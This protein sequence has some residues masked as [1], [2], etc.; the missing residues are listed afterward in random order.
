[1]MMRIAIARKKR[2]FAI[3]CHARQNRASARLRDGN[4]FMPAL[5]TVKEL[6]RAEKPPAPVS[7]LSSKSA[8]TL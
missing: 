4:F 2:E 6:S 1:M 8:K 3:R 7:T 5:P